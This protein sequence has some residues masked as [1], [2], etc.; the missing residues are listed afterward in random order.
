MPSVVVKF[1]TKPS[2][3]T[4]SRMQSMIL[5]NETW[6]A[7]NLWVSAHM[8]MHMHMRIYIYTYI[9]IYIHTYIHTYMYWDT[10]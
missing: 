8:H 2:Q 1:V 3:M 5:C 9:C 10:P 7:L 6:E 4:V